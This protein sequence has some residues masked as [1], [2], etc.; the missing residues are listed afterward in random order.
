MGIPGI[1]CGGY[2]VM[3]AVRPR[4]STGREGPESKIPLV[5]GLKQSIRIHPYFNGVLVNA[6]ALV[7]LLPWG[8]C[9]QGQVNANDRPAL[10]SIGKAEGQDRLDEPGVRRQLASASQPVTGTVSAATTR[11]QTVTSRASSVS[12]HGSVNDQLPSGVVTFPP[13]TSQLSSYESPGP[14]G[15]WERRGQSSTLLV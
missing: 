9:L 7:T 12:R 13:M 4:R 6:R 3:S 5:G 8:C 15:N 1:G 14:A 11:S 2:F 10:A